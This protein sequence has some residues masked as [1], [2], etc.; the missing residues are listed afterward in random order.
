[1][2]KLKEKSK[3]LSTKK[4]ER[5]VLANVFGGKYMISSFKDGK[6]QYTDAWND[7]NGDGIWNGKEKGFVAVG[8]TIYNLPY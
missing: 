5:N 1:M 8:G 7:E 4:L 2:K 3:N 6:E